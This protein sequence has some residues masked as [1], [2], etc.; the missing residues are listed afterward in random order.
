[1]KSLITLTALFLAIS[2]CNSAIDIKSKIEK[3][4]SFTHPSHELKYLEMSK[5]FYLV[6]SDDELYLYNSEADIIVPAPKAV[7]L[8]KDISIE[9]AVKSGSIRMKSILSINALNGIR[10]MAESSKEPSNEKPMSDPMEIQKDSRNGRVD[11]ATDTDISKHKSTPISKQ[12]IPI[13]HDENSTSQ[14]VVNNQAAQEAADLAKKSGEANLNELKMQLAKKLE[15]A[16]KNTG[17]NQTAIEPLKITP[18]LDNNNVQHSP[19]ASTSNTLTSGIQYAYFNGVPVLKIA[20]GEDGKLLSKEAKKQRI[21]DTAAKMPMSWTVNYP[22]IGKE[23]LQLFVFTDYT[24]PFCHKLHNDIQLLNQA[25]IT[26]R[27]MYYSRA[28]SAGP[29]TPGAVL[30]MEQMRRSWCAPDQAEAFSELFETRQ[31]EDFKCEDSLATKNRPDFPGPYQHFMG[32]LFDLDAT[33]LYFTNDGQMNTGYSTFTDFEK[34]KI[35]IPK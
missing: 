32:Q 28:Y 12:E 29:R 1:M 3:T 22:A 25:G 33:P 5:D 7:M 24:C 4:F 35:N 26:V 10:G 14:Q 18:L 23:K 13:A 21:I 16:K 34:T 17:I 20:Y 30:T 2:G 9:D 31:I 27:Y 6:K 15:L 19:L 8:G 11:I